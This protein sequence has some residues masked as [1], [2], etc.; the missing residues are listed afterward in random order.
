[1]SVYIHAYLVAKV[2][3]IAIAKESWLFNDSSGIGVAS[4]L[5][6]V[7]CG[8]VIGAVVKKVSE[9][10]EIRNTKLI[11]IIS[12]ATAFTAIYL[13]WIFFLDFMEKGRVI[14]YKSD[15]IWCKINELSENIKIDAYRDPQ[16]VKKNEP[17][18]KISKWSFFFYWFLD[19]ASILILIFVIACE[20]VVK[21]ILNRFGINITF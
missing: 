21:R 20:E 2:Y 12:V 18:D 1:M 8:A 15:N 17:K 13:Y 10:T 5:C 6:G 9:I 4:T 14:S 3:I 11:V 7:F 16:Y 19:A